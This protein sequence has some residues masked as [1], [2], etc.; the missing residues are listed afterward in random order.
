MEVK[1]SL[2]DNVLDGNGTRESLTNVIQTGVT[3]LLEQIKILSDGIRLSIHETHTLGLSA[4]DVEKLESIEDSLTE[5][6]F[7]VL[8]AYK[9][10]TKMKKIPNKARAL[11]CCTNI[12][13][14]EDGLSK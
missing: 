13:P 12:Q 1:D 8:K 3:S 11:D 2:F 14:E 6:Q 7:V 10:A 9:Q 5:A 4:E